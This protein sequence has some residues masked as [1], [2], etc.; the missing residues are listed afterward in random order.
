MMKHS[1]LLCGVIAAT[2]SAGLRAEDVAGDKPVTL[3]FCEWNMGHFD[4]GT[5]D[6]NYV[7]SDH[8]PIFCTLTM[9]GGAS[10]AKAL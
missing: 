5:A 2:L 4:L 1:W 7:L 3:R 8:R 9:K 10:R 6:D